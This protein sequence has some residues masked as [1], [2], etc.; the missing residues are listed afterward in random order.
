[1]GR[2]YHLLPLIGCC[3]V[4]VLT[5]CQNLSPPSSHSIGSSG[6]PPVVAPA[7]PISN[8]MPT[9]CPLP[10]TARPAV[11]AKMVMATNH[12]LVYAYNNLDSHDPAHHIGTLFRYDITNGS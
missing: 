4:F 7:S 1:M 3:L 8:T 12:A 11:L 10:G 9:D 2:R 5:A 6:S